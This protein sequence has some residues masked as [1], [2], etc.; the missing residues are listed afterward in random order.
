MQSLKFVE[1]I[2]DRVIENNTRTYKDLLENT[3]DAK[4]PIWKEILPIYNNLT[5]EQKKSFLQ[6]MRMVSVN[7]VSHIFGILDGSTYLNEENDRYNLS[8][9]SDGRLL[10]GELQ[11][12]FLELEEN[13]I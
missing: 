12:I 11:D 4:D 10:N 7:T 8:T 3:K 1:A 2:R 5:G 13:D 6:F 9:E